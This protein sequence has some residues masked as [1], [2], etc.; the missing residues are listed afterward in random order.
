VGVIDT[1]K[2]VAVL[3]QELNNMELVKGDVP[4]AVEI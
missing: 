3:V 4:V 1:I 2:D